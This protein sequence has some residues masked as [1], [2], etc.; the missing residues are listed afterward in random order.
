M[1][2]KDFKSLP[3]LLD[4]FKKEQV[5]IKYFERL[6]W[7]G[8]PQCPKCGH[9]KVY[10]TKAGYKCASSKCRK[11]FT[12]KVGTVFEGS[13]ISLRIWF[14]AMYLV[15]S[16]KKGI[17]SVQL[18]KD[19]G[20]TQKTGWFIAHRLREVLTDKKQF[21]LSKHVEVD[22]TFYGGKEK[23]KPKHRRTPGTQGRSTE[24]KVAILG[25][26]QRDGLVYAHKVPDV[27]GTTLQPIINE[28]VSDG[29]IILTDEWVGYK[30]LPDKFTHLTVNHGKGIYVDGIAHTNSLEGFW[31]LL[32]RGLYGIYHCVSEKHID[33]YINE[34]AARYNTRT[35]SESERFNKFL[36]QSQGRLKYN[37]LIGKGK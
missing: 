37:N 14:A 15:S 29:S 1:L 28:K 19:L 20:V 23:N 35:Y 8:K 25:L 32:K 2:K 9:E 27:K 11:N 4:Y 34:F 10:H 36:I 7:N 3:V 6:R 17:S 18:A 31:S 21:K 24:T 13:N 22:E 12:V 30:N 16:H 5:C 33:R 26:L